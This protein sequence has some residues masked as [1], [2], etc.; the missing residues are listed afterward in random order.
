MNERFAPRVIL[1]SLPL[2]IFAILLLLILGRQSLALGMFLGWLWGVL[3]FLQLVR[4][5][6]RFPRAGLG[7]FPRL[8][9]A[10]LGFILFLKL[11]P[12]VFLGALIGFFLY[13][14][15]MVIILA[16]GPKE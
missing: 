7:S 8:L 5:V 1:L 13:K 14:P 6:K 2:A 11:G 12:P 10:A 3:Y 9:F 15:P 4:G 16:L